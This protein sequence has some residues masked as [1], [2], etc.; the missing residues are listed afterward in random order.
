[1]LPRETVVVAGEEEM[2]DMAI[3]GKCGVERVKRKCVRR[4]MDGRYF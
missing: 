1:M 3:Y 2:A 4:V